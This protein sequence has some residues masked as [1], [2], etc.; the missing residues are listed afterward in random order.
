MPSIVD[1]A[2]RFPVS[3]LLLATHNSTTTSETMAEALQLSPSPPVPSA[4]DDEHMQDAEER[5]RK[6][7]QVIEALATAK[8]QHVYLAL[9]TKNQEEQFA[10]AT[11]QRAKLHNEAM[12]QRAALHVQQNQQLANLVETLKAQ[13]ERADNRATLHAQQNQQ[14]ANLVETLKAQFER[15]EQLIIAHT[16]QQNGPSAISFSLQKES[17]ASQ[18]GALVSFASHL[19]HHKLN[20]HPLGIY[21][22][23]RIRSGL[24]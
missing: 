1:I 16:A 2:A 23:L 14:L 11:K 9:A 24:V 8:Q 12:E 17:V 13:F 18:T 21:P 3:L 5:E 4:A 22:V 7:A 6:Q 15:A 19:Y 10:L 20:F